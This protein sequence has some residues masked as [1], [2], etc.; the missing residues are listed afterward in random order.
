MRESRSPRRRFAR[1]QCGVPDFLRYVRVLAE[2][3][4]QLNPQATLYAN[5]W[6]ISYWGKEPLAQGWKG[7]FEKEIVGSREVVA[8][9]DAAAKHAGLIRSNPSPSLPLPL[10]AETWLNDLRRSIG[11]MTWA[12]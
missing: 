10:S 9:R 12:A 3:L 1:G 4:K 11:R 6:R 7:V 8:H 5:T 2:R